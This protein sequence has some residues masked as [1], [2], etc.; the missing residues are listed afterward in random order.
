MHA[1]HFMYALLG[2]KNSWHCGLFPFAISASSVYLTFCLSFTVALSRTC[3]LFGSFSFG[4][5]RVSFPSERGLNNSSGRRLWACLC[6]FFCP[7]LGALGSGSGFSFGLDSL[8]LCFDL[9]N[10]VK[11]CRWK[12][13]TTR[14]NA[15][16]TVIVRLALALAVQLELQPGLS[17]GHK[18][19]AWGWVN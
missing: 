16:A 10:K 2:N 4:E 6:N 7:A 9:D 8:S 17:P 1:T 3:C 19:A 13:A 15:T 14:A 11:T 18:Y 5:L 12:I